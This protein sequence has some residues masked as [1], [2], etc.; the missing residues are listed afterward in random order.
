[1][2]FFVFTLKGEYLQEIATQLVELQ[3][4]QRLVSYDNFLEIFAKLVV[5]L[6]EDFNVKAAT[7]FV[8]LFFERTTQLICRNLQ[9]NGQTLIESKIK[10]EFQSQKAFIEEKKIKE[11]KKSIEIANRYVY[12]E[13]KLTYN[14]SQVDELKRD[15]YS[16]FDY[17]IIGEEDIIPHGISAE[18]VLHYVK[19]DKDMNGDNI[20]IKHL[21]FN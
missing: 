20:K 4:R 5:L 21:Q 10:V 15:I 7:Q 16:N 1:M 9:T 13:E 14:E 12:F 19:N 3:A 17:I 8:Q 2:K 6:I 11:E 18:N